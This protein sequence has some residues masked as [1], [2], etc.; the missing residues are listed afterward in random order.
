MN[1]TISEME[2]A[3]IRESIRN[4]CLGGRICHPIPEANSKMLR[5][6]LDTNG[7]DEDGFIMAKY[8]KGAEI[9]SAGI[10]TDESILNHPKLKYAYVPLGFI[11]SGDIVVIKDGKGLKQ[12]SKGDFL[13]LFETSDALMT[14]KRRQVG[15]WTLVASTDVTVIYFP[16]TIFL[17]SSAP[18]ITFRNFVIESARA[19]H[20][21]QPN[22]SLPLLDWV[23]SHTTKDRPRDCAI[24]AHTHLLP[25]NLPLFRHLSALLDFGRIYVMDKPYSTVRSVLNELVLSGFEVI[26]VRMDA[27]LPYEFAVSKSLDVLWDKVI[28]D[29]KR[30]QYKKLL[31]IDDGGDVWQSIPWN[32]LEGVAI[33]A[34]EQTQR[35]IART[36]QSEMR[37]PPIVS[38]ASSG[39]KKI[40][41]S[42]F[43]GLSI[44]KK[45][46]DI[47]SLG[48][49]TRVGIVGMG[50]I[51]IAVEKALR[52]RGI[53]ALFYDPKYYATQSDTPRKRDSL[54]VLLDEC[55]LIIGT[56]GTDALKGL[57]FERVT[58]GRKILA[59]ASS[60]D[61]EFS[62]LLKLAST[63]SD[64]FE[65]VTIPLHDQLTIEIINGG[66]PIN[67]DRIKD[68]TPD[69]DI[70]LTRC[71]MYIGAMQALERIDN[72]VLESAV[73]NID[74]VSQ[75]R[76]L[77]RW[78]T[79]KNTSG[80]GTHFAFNEVDEIVASSSYIG[81]KD[82]PTVWMDDDSR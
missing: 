66:Y 16:G 42:E 21:P 53:S 17:E 14:G 32:K 64:P 77:E 65:T 52:E 20:V 75:K 55:D 68:S 51:G 2:P 8:C 30:R 72:G 76:T 73:Y 35:G 58:S 43:I 33:A 78:I 46:A 24:I 1:T 12:L 23:A 44:V 9:V 22:T 45:L 36:V 7:Q 48:I 27:N 80:H 69:D 10:I 25:N 4:I 60:A 26:P 38:V 15:D 37:F 6:Y 82:M 71:L 47:G 63:R 41:E 31:I 34:V 67:F 39:I 13:G 54:D 40:V 3:A 57:P 28:D 81:G 74:T 56:T 49:A 70:V 29:Q 11:V 62:S 50:S 79:E 19:D 61:L 59:S 5:D 18:A